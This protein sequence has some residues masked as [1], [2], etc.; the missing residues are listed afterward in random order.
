MSVEKLVHDLSKQ[1]ELL[2][3]VRRPKRLLLRSGLEL[4]TLICARP[5]G[6]TKF[7]LGFAGKYS[8]VLA[9]C[10]SSRPSML[11]VAPH[12]SR[13]DDAWNGLGSGLAVGGMSRSSAGW[14]TQ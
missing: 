4:S 7:I 12:G 3:V 13:E 10:M 8:V 11:V 1:H 9:N 6:L 14:S 2:K 5:C